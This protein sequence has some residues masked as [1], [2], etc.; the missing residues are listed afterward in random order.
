MRRASARMIKFADV[1]A[2]HDGLAGTGIVRQ[3][4]PQRLPRQ[5]RLVNGGD[6]VRQRFDVRRVDRHHGV[7]QERQVDALGFDG[8][9]ER[10]AVAVEGP[11]PFDGGE[12]DAC[13]VGPAQQPLLE[14]TVRASCR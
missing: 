3:D 2:R 12:A 8:E 9:L 10:L 7:E 11:W 13:F 1:K 5:H 4:E 6:L 14:R